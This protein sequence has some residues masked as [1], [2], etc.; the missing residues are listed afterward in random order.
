MDLPE[1]DRS[2]NGRWCLPCVDHSSQVSRT[3]GVEVGHLLDLFSVQRAN[4]PA[5]V[6]VKKTGCAVSVPTRSTYNA[7]F[8]AGFHHGGQK[9]Y[10]SLC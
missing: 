5:T 1:S 6:H 4:G 7:W 3:L 8:T 2:A 9:T 10:T